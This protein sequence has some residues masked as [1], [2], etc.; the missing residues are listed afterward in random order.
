MRYHLTPWEWSRSKRLKAT[1]V[2][3]EMMA[4][5]GYVIWFSLYKKQWQFPEQVRMKLPYD[6]V[7]A[8]PGISFQNTKIFIQIVA[9]GWG[10]EY[11]SRGD[12]EGEGCGDMDG[13]DVQ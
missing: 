13:R 9:D 3:G 10:D 2:D 8:L 7:N 4:K 1:N 6:L 5:L 11:Q 12:I